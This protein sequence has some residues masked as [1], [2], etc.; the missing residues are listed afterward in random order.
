MVSVPELAERIGRSDTH[1]R[2][3]LEQLEYLGQVERKDV[4]ARATA[5][6]HVDRVTGPVDE[7]AAHAGSEGA[8]RRQETGDT[9]PGREAVADPD[10]PAGLADLDFPAGRDYQQC[11]DAVYAARDYIEAHDGAK[12]SELVREVMPEH[13]VGYDAEADVARIED[14]DERNRST[15]WRKV[16]RPGLEAL[17][18]IEKPPRG[19]SEWRYTG[20]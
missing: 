7:E 17:D 14:P 2:Q 3:Q 13:P 1:V 10:Q 11:A 5:W 6:W 8:E 12:M 18:E 16:V 9:D 15:W 4:G 20:P 19:G